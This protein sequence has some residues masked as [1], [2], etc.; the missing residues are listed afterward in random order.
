MS[1]DT[2]TQAALDEAN[3]GFWSELC[4][5]SL[6][7]AIGLERDEPNALERFDDAYF[8]Y[9]PYLKKFVDRYD[10]AG[11]RVLEIGL[12][13]G[14][15]GQYIAAA[16]ADYHG[17]DIAPTP[18]EMMRHRLQLLGKSPDGVVQGSALAIPWPDATFDYVYS[19][20]CLH[21]TGDLAGSVAEVH[22]VLKPGGDAVIMLYNRYSARQL[23]RIDRLRLAGALKR[24]RV[25]SAERVRADYDTNE[26][27]EAAP[28]TD[29][30]SRRG[31][32]RLLSAFS[33]VAIEAE[34]LDPVVVRQKLVCPREP[35]IEGPL[36]RLFGLD[37]YITATK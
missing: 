3:A 32:R 14:T 24:G 29:F 33:R 37:L 23:W 13:Y 6:A 18:V 31:A 5:S 9:Y 28:H 7:R 27:G 34:N 4:G 1:D 12:G 26:S 30:T 15:L 35:L 2:V 21:H 36:A 16:G 10:L 25:P 8:G 19:I 22:R 11:K 17:L 20:G